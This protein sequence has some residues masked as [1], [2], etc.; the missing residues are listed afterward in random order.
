MKNTGDI[1]KIKD[2]LT[3]A[4]TEE[5]IYIAKFD[6]YMPV[7]LQA[8]SKEELLKRARAMGLSTASF[9]EKMYSQ[10]EPFILNEIP[11]EE[12]P[13]DIEN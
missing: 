10:E 6:I 9:F 13:D 8:K 12:W 3:Y 2:T 5:G 7:I 1:T 4:L 11:I